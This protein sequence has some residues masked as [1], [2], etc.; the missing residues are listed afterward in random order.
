MGSLKGFRKRGTKGENK[1]LVY[2]NIDD[3]LL[4]IHQGKGTHLHNTSPSE[5]TC[6]TLLSVIRSAQIKEFFSQLPTFHTFSWISTSYY[7]KSAQ[8][9]E[10]LYGDVQISCKKDNFRLHIGAREDCWFTTP[11]DFRLYYELISGCRSVLYNEYRNCNPIGGT[12]PALK[13]SGDAQK[14]LEYLTNK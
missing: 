4:A 13:F 11:G 5:I 7:Q 2:Q 10:H 12:I 6:W 14:V 3:T 8:D 1:K 9:Q